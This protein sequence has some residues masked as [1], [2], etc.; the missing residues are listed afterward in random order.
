MLRHCVFVSLCLCVFVLKATFLRADDEPKSRVQ[1]SKTERVDF[2][3]GGVL[4]LNNSI[5]ELTVQGWDLPEVEITTIRSTRSTYTSQEREI[6]IRDLDQV[7]IKTERHGDEVVVATEFPRYA[8][9]P[10]PVPWHSGHANFDLEYRINVPRDARLV[11]E[12]NSGEVHVENLMSDIRATV[13]KGSITLR[14]AEDNSYAIDAKSDAGGIFSEFPGQT[15]RRWALVGYRFTGKP[16]AAAH[17]LYLRVGFGDIAILKIQ[18]PPY[19]RFVG[20]QSAPQQ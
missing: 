17:Q 6:A 20:L 16:P 5:G 18:K 1:V 3:P 2:P 4:R 15:H 19:S 7:Q 14:L 11:V 9:F 8:V 13:L 12:H 10:P